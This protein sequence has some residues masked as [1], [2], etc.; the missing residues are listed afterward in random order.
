MR[1]WREPATWAPP[2][3]TQCLEGHRVE[4]LARLAQLRSTLAVIDHKLAVYD[5]LATDPSLTT[6]AAARR[7]ASGL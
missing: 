5:Q 1:D 6:A 4:M 2:A 3:A 7:R